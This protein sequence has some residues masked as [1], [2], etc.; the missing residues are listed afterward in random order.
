MTVKGNGRNL[1]TNRRAHVRNY[2]D[3][4]FHEKAITN[5][6]SLENV[7]A[8]FR[9]TYDS[10]GDGNF[11]V[12]RP[13]QQNILFEMHADGLHYHDT[14]NRQLVMVQTVHENESGFSECQVSKAKIA[15]ELYAKVGYPSIK[16]FKLMIVNNMINNCPILVEDVDRAEKLYGPSI[17]ALKGKTVRQTSV[18]VVT[19]YVEV[20]PHILRENKNITISVDVMFVN[21]I[22]FLT[23]ISRHI[24]FSTAETLPTRNIKNLLGCIYPT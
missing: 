1:K 17:Q 13:N 18:P 8:K 19:D 7:K 20:P 5:V 2:G 16:D 24:K 22:P 10:N 4:W 21:K 11:I 23:S 15:R 14:G 12:H 6:M 9:V 3:V